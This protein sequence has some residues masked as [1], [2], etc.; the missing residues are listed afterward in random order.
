[1][2]TTAAAMARDVD[3]DGGNGGLPALLDAIFGGSRKPPQNAASDG[4]EAEEEGRRA[5]LSLI[6]S[7][8]SRGSAA[9]PR[10]VAKRHFASDV[11]YVD[12]SSFYNSIMGGEA[13]VRHLYLHHAGSSSS[14]SGIMSALSICGDGGANGGRRRR[15]RR[16]VVDDMVVASS[17]AAADDNDSSA[18]VCVLYHLEEGG[19]GAV[20]VVVP[21]TTAIAFCNLRREDGDDDGEGGGGMR[22]GRL[23]D[24][25]EPPSP[26]PGDAGLRLLSSVSKILKVVG[27]KG[28]VDA[29][30]K[31]MAKANVGEGE[32]ETKMEV[33]TSTRTDD[34]VVRRYF[35]AWNRRDVA[36]ASS[37]FSED[38][39]VRDL[40]YDESFVGRGQFAKHLARVADCLPGTFRFVVD[41]VVS[42]PQG[43]GAMWH[44]ESGGSPLPFTRGCSFYS[45]DRSTG[46]IKYGYEI[47][48]KAPPKLGYL[49]TLASRFDAE[50]VRIVPAML[51][52]GYMYVL[53]FSDG[54]LP[55]ANA[56]ALEQRT[57]E[58]VRDLSINF[59]FV[60]PALHLPFSPVVHPM[61]EGVFN[62]LLAWAAMF[63][64]FL[65]DEREDK[66]NLLPFGPMLVGMQFLTSG[67]LLPYL[68]ARTS[69]RCGS[70]EEG[71]GTTPM[72]VYREDISGILQREV[73]EWRP[74]G[75]LL[76]GVG[77]SS[78]LWGLLAR[79]E[80]GDFGTRYAS[81]L[82]LLS[83]D[84]VGSSFIVD[85]VIFAAFQGWFV[86]D[87]L[88]R[89]GVAGPAES[90]LLRNAA[91]F[92]PFFGL[93]AYLTL[94]PPL[95]TREMD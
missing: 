80:Y 49:R 32:G 44:V 43:A 31:E 54:I 91:K 42:T 35:D 47:P 70:S 61:L 36:Y 13:L 45:I 30:K 12:S 10:E 60:S 3:D 40:Q 46:L 24:V 83:I 29:A 59:F 87:D 69:E 19:E 26:K 11:E 16:I 85:L 94:R 74:L 52:V 5:V 53:F 28:D 9:D 37:L 17:S 73:A 21:D 65:S 38:C 48:E 63:A 23:F 50:P 2:T 41:D 4:R 86:D 82:D 57:W 15:R 89:R 75:L 66:P 88:M 92:V 84:R 93:V 56:L 95:P 55:G 33:A 20:A 27:G 72:V 7:L 77:T 71:T 8:N 64:G 79:P 78:I 34:S 81:F 76:G 25:S 67:F 90:S 68:F 22:I 1:M 14:K 18:K 62:L 6:S 39:V 58:E 51:W